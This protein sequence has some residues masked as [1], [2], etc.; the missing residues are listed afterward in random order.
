[1][2][3]NFDGGAEGSCFIIYEFHRDLKTAKCIAE[4][5][6]DFTLA[7]VFLSKDKICVLDQN[8][9]LAVC[10]FDGSNLKKL[11]VNKKG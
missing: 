7:A 9:D 4:K 8:K 2:I 10:N 11:Q 6:G 1:V 3:L 5:R